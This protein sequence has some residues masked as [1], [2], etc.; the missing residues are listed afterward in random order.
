MTFYIKAAGTVTAMLVAQTAWAECP[1]DAGSIRLLG[2][3]FEALTLL[4]GEVRSCATDALSVE[5]N[6]TT[7]H[8]NIQAA[9]MQIEPSEYTTALVANNSIVPLVND[10]LIRPLDDLVAQYGQDLAPNQLIRIDGQV[11]AVAFMAN[12]Q[13]LFIR[14]DILE[15]AGLEQP[16]TYEEVLEA[17]EAI[18]AADIMQYPLAATDE[19]GWFLAAEFVNMYLGMGGEFFAPGSAEPAIENDVAIATLEMMQAM[20]EYM[21]PEFLTVT[22]DE[23][24][25]MYNGGNVAIMNQWGSVVNGVIGDDAA[26][27]D[28]AQATILAPAPTVGGGSTPAAAL[29][30]DGFVIAQNVSDEDAAVSFKAMVHAIRPEIA[31]EN[32][33]VATWLMEGFDAPE[34]AMGVL[35]TAMGGAKAYPMSPYMGLM[36]TALGSELAQFMQGSEDAARALADVSASYRTS[37]QE[38]GY[39][40]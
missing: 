25:N 26:N 30:W 28:I 6:L 29:W 9:A 10:G 14:G 31:A 1:T 3:D 40:N 32:P 12:A 35:G 4:A 2:N 20:T 13:H 19:A 23:M 7:E 22:A 16:E 24:N 17:A 21:A 8:K 27:A 38:A 11:M 37:A 34:S 39:L 33:T 5:V 18:R 15:E 36:H